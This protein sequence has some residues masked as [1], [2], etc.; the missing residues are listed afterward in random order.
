MRCPACRSEEIHMSKSGNPWF[1]FPLVPWIVVCFRCHECMC[2][3]YR[4]RLFSRSWK[5]A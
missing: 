1:L 3:F 2:K 5:R 4:L